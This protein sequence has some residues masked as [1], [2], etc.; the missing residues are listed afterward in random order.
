MDDP[1]PDL[2][3]REDREF[4]AMWAEAIWGL[5]LIGSVIAIVAVVVAL[6]P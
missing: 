3:R 6:A 1:P 5:G 4:S 2:E